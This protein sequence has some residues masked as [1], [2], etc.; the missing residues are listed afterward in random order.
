MKA[1]TKHRSRSAAF[2]RQVARSLLPARRCTAYRGG[3]DTVIDAVAEPPNDVETLT[4]RGCG[5]IDRKDC[6][7]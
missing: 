6:Q 2:K 4:R 7:N 3:I 1:M 5:R